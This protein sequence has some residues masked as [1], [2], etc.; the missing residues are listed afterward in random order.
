MEKEGKGMPG[1][2]NNNGKNNGKLWG[3][4]WE[5]QQQKWGSGAAHRGPVSQTQGW[6]LVPGEFR[7][8][9]VLSKVVT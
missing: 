2:G 9:R 5:G 8:T 3:T 4:N 6:D 1:R 7:G